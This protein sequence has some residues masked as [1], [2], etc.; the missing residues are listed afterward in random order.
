MDRMTTWVGMIA[1][2]RTAARLCTTLGVALLAAALVL[3][4]LPGSPASCGSLLAPMYPPSE[5]I[6]CSAAQGAWLPLVLAAVVIGLLLLGAGAAVVPT[7]R[8]R[9]RR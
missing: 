1:T 4:L 7:R 8:S 3:A 5:G 9:R 6:V 2:R